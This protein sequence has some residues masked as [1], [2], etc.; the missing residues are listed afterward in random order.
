[1]EIVDGQGNLFEIVLAAHPIGGLADFLDGRQQQ[2]N[3]DGDDG[4]Y[5]Q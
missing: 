2:A 3:Q 4:N 1:M 5:H